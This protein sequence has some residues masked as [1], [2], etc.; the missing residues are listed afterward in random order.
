MNIS[1]LTIELLRAEEVDNLDFTGL[2]GLINSVY[3]VAESEFWVEGHNRTNTS[4]LLKAIQNSEVIVARLNGDITACVHVT[5][6]GR[7]TAKFG[8]LSVPV[9]YEGNGIGGQLVKAAERHAFDSGCGKMRLEVLTSNELEHDGKQRLQDWYT[10]L[11]YVFMQQFPFDEVAPV[12]VQHL[13]TTC[14]FDVYEKDLV[15]TGHQAP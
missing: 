3:T 9:Q 6:D 10:R 13:R 5:M 15:D 14:F 12:D 4:Y 8:M 1:K 2:E 7:G 11:G